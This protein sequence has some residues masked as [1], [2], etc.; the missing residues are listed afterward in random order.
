MEQIYE[1]RIGNYIIRNIKEKMTD[2]DIEGLDGET[3]HVDEVDIH[4]ML[5]TTTSGAFQMQWRED[6]LMYAMLDN[7][8]NDEDQRAQLAV[9]MVLQNAF[10]VGNSCD[11]S[12]IFKTKDGKDVVDGL[13][14]S[15]MDAITEYMKRVSSYEPEDGDETTESIID[16]MRRA[17]SASTTLDE[18]TAQVAEKEK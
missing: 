18:I 13:Q 8:L 14:R 11:I 12:H 9:Q 16:E 10:I 7:F 3:R 4:F 1:K 6:S 15:V 17:Y 2:V 5:L